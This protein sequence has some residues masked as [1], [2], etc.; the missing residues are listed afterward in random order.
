[1][2]GQVNQRKA[3]PP[4][5]PQPPPGVK[6]LRDLAY[7]PHGHER[8]KLDLYLPQQPAGAL[9]LVLWIHPGGGQGG[10]K[11]NTRALYLTTQGYAVASINH[12]LIQH[13]IF[14]AQIH[15]CKAAIRW[16]RAHAKE[17]RL[18]PDRIG[19]W[20]ASSGGT[21]AALLGTTGGLNDL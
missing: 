6:A 5:P 11:E 3:Q 10:S 7:V 19:V 21:L 13:A 8:Q 1:V 12:R 17:Y 15:D 2:Q 16:L 18:D 14:P 4:G 9:P 20:G